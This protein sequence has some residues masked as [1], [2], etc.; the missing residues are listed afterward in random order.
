MLFVK[1]LISL[2]L[3]IR[4]CKDGCNLSRTKDKINHILY[5]NEMKTFAKEGA[6]LDAAVR[7]FSLDTGMKFGT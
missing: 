3:T 4:K 6:G 1:A 5:M 2:N 7:V